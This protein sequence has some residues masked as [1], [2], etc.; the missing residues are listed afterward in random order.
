VT[1][2][3]QFWQLI[4]AVF[5]VMAL[6]GL[7]GLA[8]GALLRNQIVAVVAALVWLLAAERL[9]ID[10]LPEV[11]RWTLAGASYA[12]LQLGPITAGGTLLDAPVGGLLLLGYTAAAV[13]LAL[14]VAPRR[15]VL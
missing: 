13:V 9:L 14:V 7:I 15:D 3:A 8:V 2:G 12:L 6:Y 11:E 1:I 10:A 5:V 4:P